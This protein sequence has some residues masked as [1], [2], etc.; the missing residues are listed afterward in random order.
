MASFLVFCASLARRLQT[1]KH[2]SNVV[3][4]ASLV[5]ELGLVQYFSLYAEFYQGWRV[6]G[7][8]GDSVDRCAMGSYNC[9]K[10]GGSQL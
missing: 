3:R 4:V 9:Y 7:C 8:S 5:R 10:G 6:G 2:W 1:V